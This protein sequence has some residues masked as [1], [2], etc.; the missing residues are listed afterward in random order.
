[1]KNLPFQFHQQQISLVHFYCLQQTYRDQGCPV[2]H[3]QIRQLHM[4]CQLY[5][6]PAEI[7]KV[8]MRPG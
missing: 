3:F 8:N 4:H 1:M 5:Q 6:A 7:K 2:N